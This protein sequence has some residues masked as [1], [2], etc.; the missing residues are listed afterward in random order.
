MSHDEGKRL[1]FVAGPPRSGTT[2]VQNILDSHSQVVGAPEFPHIRRLV[3]IRNDLHNDIDQGSIDTF[4]TKGDIDAR[5]AELIESLLLPF[6]DSSNCKLVSEKTP[7]NV[8]AF[9]DLLA[10]FRHARF[11]LVI[12]DPRAVVASLLRVRT[13]MLESGIRPT[14]PAANFGSALRHTQRY[15]AAGFRAQATDPARVMCVPYE[16]L[17]TNPRTIT[18]GICDHLG[19]EWEEALMTPS[20]FSHVGE[21][22]ITEASGNVWYTH[23]EFNTDPDPHRVDKWRA[24]LSGPQQA[25]ICEAFAHERQLAKF[26]YDLSL[27]PLSW[28]D[29]LQGRLQEGASL[30]VFRALSTR[31]GTRAKS[32]VRRHIA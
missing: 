7:K 29:R 15:L 21:T 18:K 3:D 8:I 4:H 25:R 30:T 24:S 6:A 10:L 31:L 14:G 20:R 2:L 23:S 27:Y 12:R 26:G 9:P 11:L 1:V 19:L 22:A 32:A 16:T 28:S 17:V 5:F 13:R